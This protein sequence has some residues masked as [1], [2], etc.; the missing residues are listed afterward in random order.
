M[1]SSTPSIVPTDDQTIYMVLESFG[2][3]GC[4]WRETSLVATGLETAMTGLLENH[5]NDPVRVIG[6]N[7]AEGWARDVSADLAD[8]IRRRCDLQQT[9]IP[10]HLEA[11]VTRHE[12]RLKR[13]SSVSPT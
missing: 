9:G 5:Y 7:T 12:N 6:F 8:E 4:S 13:R 10:R 11:F 3:L 2:E 1:A